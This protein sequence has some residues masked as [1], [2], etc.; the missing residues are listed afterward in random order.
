MRISLS[1]VRFLLEAAFLVLVAAAAGLAG[2]DAIWIG[3]VMFGAW[4]LVAL[5][6][7]SGSRR[8]ARATEAAEAEAETRRAETEAKRAQALAEKLR[9]LGID[10]NQI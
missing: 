3:V 5:V 2:L 6:E 8:R 4:A 10:P 1:L 7:R 9:S